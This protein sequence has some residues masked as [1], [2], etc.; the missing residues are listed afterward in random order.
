M[1]QVG[2][3]EYDAKVMRYRF[4]D[5]PYQWFLYEWE[6]D[7]TQEKLKKLA[8]K[9]RSTGIQ[10]RVVKPD[11]LFGK[12][13]KHGLLGI[14]LTVDECIAWI[15]TKNGSIQ[16]IDARQWILHTFLVEPHIAHEEELYISFETQRTSD[17]LYFSTQWWVE[18]ESVW[19]SVVNID[20]PLTHQ[21]IEEWLIEKLTKNLPDITVS[22]LTPFIGL[23]VQFVRTHWITYLEVN[24]LVMNNDVLHCLDMV[25]KVDTTEFWKQ[26]K[27]WSDLTFV[28]P[29][30][31]VSHFLEDIIDE[32]DRKSYASVQFR[33]MNPDGRIG[34][35]LGWWGAS[36]VV[37]DKLA[38]MGLIDEVINY[39]DLSWNPSYGDNKAYIEWVIKLMLWNNHQK[40]YLCYMWWIANFTKIDVLCRAYI[41]ALT[42]YIDQL[43]SK[44]IHCVIRRG[45]PGDTVWLS[46]VQ[47]FLTKNEIPH[48]IA[49]GDEYLT[50]VL[51]N[52]AFK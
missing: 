47:A 45:W 48:L 11:Q 12:R 14:W 29:F 51:E 7:D 30:G 41:D 31:N 39:G 34:L 27:H 23:L 44:N 43:R 17:R 33:I 16:T 15:H 3:R 19:D 46:Q 28:K 20:I 2:I 38:E 13:W 10:R 37:M 25:A 50:T 35:L 40:Q 9:L 36:V 6:D 24:P 52:I 26:T 32:L 5:T 4:C 49:D 1:A 22:L 8:Y 18:I 21:I 42:P